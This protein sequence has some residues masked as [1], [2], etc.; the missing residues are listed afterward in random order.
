[1]MVFIV[2]FVLYFIDI[3]DLMLDVFILSMFVIN[4]IVWW[5]RYNGIY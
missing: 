5:L 2:Y 1:M 3:S 4:I